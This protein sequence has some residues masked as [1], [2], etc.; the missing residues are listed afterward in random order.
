MRLLTHLFAPPASRLFP[1]KVL[2]HITSA[3]AQ[4]ELKHSGEICFAVEPALHWRAVVAGQSAEARARDVFSQLRV[5]D[6][7]CNNGVLV[8]L[9]LADRRIEIVAD[10]G[11][12]G[13]VDPAQWREACAVMERG[14][15]SGSPEQAML[16]G[17]AALTTLI[18]HHFPRDP[19]VDDRD[20]LPNRP[21]ML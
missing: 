11:F 19:A 3:I 1:G 12:A 16:D 17:I 18:A 2:E 20:E 9:L 21:H 5:W 14:L 10:R 6:T 13:R 15:R 8:Y 7:E 4:S